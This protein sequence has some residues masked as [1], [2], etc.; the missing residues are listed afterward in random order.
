M[1]RWLGGLWLTG[2]SAAVVFGGCAPTTSDIGTLD[3]VGGEGGAQEG[4][5]GGSMNHPGGGS[6]NEPGAGSMNMPRAGSENQPDQCVPGSTRTADCNTCTCTDE[7]TWACTDAACEC[8]AGDMREADDGCNT[9]SCFEGRWAC[10]MRQ[11]GDT[12]TLGQI[13]SDD[14]SNCVCTDF[15][16]GPVWACTL[17]ECQCV[18]G[19]RRPAED[20]CNYCTCTDGQWE[21]SLLGCVVCTPGEVQTDDGCNQCT[22]DGSGQWVCEDVCPELVC[23]PGYADCDGDRANGCE[24]NVQ[25]DVMN[26]GACG[27]YCAMVGAISACVAGVCTLDTCDA[28]YGDCNGDPDDGCEVPVGDG[29]CANRCEPPA[30]SPAPVP[31]EGS[32][33]CPEG[34]GCVIGS[35]ENPDGEYCFPLPEPCPSFGTCDCLATCV[36]PRDS[37]FLCQEHMAPGGKM[38]VDCTAEFGVPF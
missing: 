23:D 25:D 20:G 3:E 2:M 8:E 18:E 22:C 28:G 4:P 19:E 38:N 5:A 32:C 14:C 31:S 33:Q 24:T 26:C 11:C 10:T 37:G 7:G 35:V 12:C 13:Q 1:N 17:N 29:E 6:G 9:C 16:D 15:G 21:C 30:D 34:M 36:C 27:N